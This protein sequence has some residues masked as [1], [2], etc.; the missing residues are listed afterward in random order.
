MR[1]TKNQRGSALIELSLLFTILMLLFMGILDFSLVIQEAM[2]VNEAAYAAA[3]YGAVSG[4]SSNFST[5]QTIATNS[6]K[7]VT[8]FS[9]TAT[10][11]CACSPGGTAVLCTSSCP[12]YGTPIGYV[13]VSTSATA[14]I[15][16]KY[17]DFR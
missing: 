2:V 1:P 16:F 6:A 5:M 9:V 4:N 8:G 7:G 17:E 14:A 11:W 12:S 15:L 3:Q 10:K 13:Q